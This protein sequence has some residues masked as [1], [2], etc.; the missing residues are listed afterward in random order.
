MPSSTLLVII[1]GVYFLLMILFLIVYGSRIRTAPP[2]QVM[3]ISGRKHIV[4]D[5]ETNEVHTVGYRLVRGGRAFVWPLLESV[6]TISLELVPVDVEVKDM[7]TDDM[8]PVSLSGTAQVKVRSDFA[9]LSIA[10]ENLLSKS[11]AEIADIA[12]DLSIKHIYAVA[13]KW[14]AAALQKD[15]TGFAQSVQHAAA[16]DLASIGLQIDS[17]VIKE[18][19]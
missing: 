19:A 10:V 5:P 13:G 18:L 6:E 9:G 8:T 3:V 1:I 12:R 7:L 14:S 2:N 17:F 15:R 4:Q 16:L 11:R